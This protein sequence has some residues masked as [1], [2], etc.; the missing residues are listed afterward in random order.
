MNGGY[1]ARFALNGDLGRLSHNVVIPFSTYTRPADK[2]I[3]ATLVEYT[4]EL[5]LI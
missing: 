2:Q 4:S 3:C 5:S 1:F